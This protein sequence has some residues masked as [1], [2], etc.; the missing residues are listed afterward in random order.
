[1]N[2]V[3]IN[4]NYDPK[5]ASGMGE[6]VAMLESGGY[7]VYIEPTHTT[8]LDEGTLIREL[9]GCRA[10]I[11]S[12][13]PFTPRVMDACPELKIISRT[14]VGYETI[15]IPAATE[16]GIAVCIT[17]G[18]GAESVSEYALALMLAVSRNVAL[19]DR[20]VRAGKWERSI[21]PVLWHKTLGVIGT[22]YIGKKLI[23]L[24]T[25]FGMKVLAYDLRR[26]EAFARQY[27]VTYCDSL[28]E[29]LTQ[30]DYVSVHVNLTE[31]TRNLIGL[32]EM[33]K[34]KPSSIIINVARGGIINEDGLHRALSSGIIAGAGLD[35]FAAEPV[36][37]DNPLLRLDNV[38]CSA[39]NAGSSNE[40]KNYTMEA[41]V[42][43]VLDV[44]AGKTPDGM[45][46]KEIFVK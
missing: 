44:D 12:V 7:E 19:Q 23:Q 22:G 20:L 33:K 8:I 46:N 27:N 1:M 3:L 36:N 45:L 18:T 9:S 21:G 10:F 4:L 2:K 17:P 15:D 24:S 41:A 26:D 42:Q 32:E 5:G 29:L 6:F 11:G 37:K 14:G 30:S 34:M 16:R 25:G 31:R 35:V 38:V 28:D 40:G 39:H 13:C 43:N